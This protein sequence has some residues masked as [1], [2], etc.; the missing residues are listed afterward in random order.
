[1]RPTGMHIG[2]VTGI[3]GIVIEGRQG[4]NLNRNQS[5][6][7]GQITGR[8]R[9]RSK[10]N[11]DMKTRSKRIKSE[12]DINQRTQIGGGKINGKNSRR[13]REK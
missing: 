12:E 6:K 9:K 5:E 2:I 10:R 3:I 1:M 7:K 4:R 13:E 11:S 8:R